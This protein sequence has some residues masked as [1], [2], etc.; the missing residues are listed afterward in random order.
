MKTLLVEIWVKGKFW[1]MLRKKKKMN[2]R[3]SFYHHRVYLY[4][5]KQN[6]AKNMNVKVLL[7]IMVS[8]GNEEH[9]IRHWTKGS[10]VR[11]WQKAWLECLLS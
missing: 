9:V 4:C 10:L 6:V 11:K 5:H 2:C 1:Q 7:V 3:E 8:D